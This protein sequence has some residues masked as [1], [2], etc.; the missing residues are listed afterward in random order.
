MWVKTLSYIRIKGKR[1]D[2]H[3]LDHMILPFPK[4]KI[5]TDA[6]D[7][8]LSKKTDD[9]TVHEIVYNDKEKLKVAAYSLSKTAVSLP[10]KDKKMNRNCLYICCPREFERTAKCIGHLLEQQNYKGNIR[11]PS[12]PFLALLLILLIDMV[13]T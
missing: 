8:T 7:F 1:I 10:S 2:D 3:E 6:I 13:A 11:I 12:V 9:S 4:N 5:E